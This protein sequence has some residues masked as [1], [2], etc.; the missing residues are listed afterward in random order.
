MEKEPAPIQYAYLYGPHKAGETRVLRN[1][2]LEPEDPQ[3]VEPYPGIDTLLKAFDRTAARIPD[4]PFLGT[5]ELLGTEEE[6]DA[7]TGRPQQVKKFG[8]YHWITF[9][10]AKSTSAAL[11]QAI[12][13]RQLCQTDSSSG[14]RY[15]FFGM[16]S[17]NRTEWV[18][19]DLALMHADIASVC[20]YETLGGESFEYIVKETNLTA[21]GCSI[22]DLATLFKY[23]EAGQIST[24]KNI[25]CYDSVPAAAYE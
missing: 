1:A 21:L 10:E 6:K 3:P 4:A 22:E 20:L 8:A 13:E 5:R 18:L 11:A 2:A 16:Y 15:R 23:K 12:E 24:L 19:M 9:A 17:R 7:R 25:V 14:T